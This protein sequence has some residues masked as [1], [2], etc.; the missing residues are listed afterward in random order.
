MRM[1]DIIHKKREGGELTEQELVFFV[2]GFSEGKIPDYQASAFLMAV[3]FR[4]MTRRETACLTLEMAHSGEMAEL[5]GGVCRLRGG[6]G[7]Y[8]L[9]GGSGR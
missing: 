7:G 8:A 9:H 2:R 6:A 5:S 4:G 3:L 1:V